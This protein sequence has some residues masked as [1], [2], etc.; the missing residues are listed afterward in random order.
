MRLV[1]LL[2]FIA[3]GQ[4]NLSAAESTVTLQDPTHVLQAYLRAIYARDFVEAY[5]FIS[6]ADATSA[7]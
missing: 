5:R 7:I 2:A 4:G 3:F 1:I 6:S